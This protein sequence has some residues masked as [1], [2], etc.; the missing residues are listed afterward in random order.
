MKIP[1]SLPVG[2]TPA[3]RVARAYGIAPTAPAAAPA[4][5]AKPEAAGG[6]DAL[7]SILTEEERAYFDQIAALGPISYAPNRRGAPAADAPRGLRLDVTG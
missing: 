2:S 5:A 4:P 6:H 7:R 1:G 3:I